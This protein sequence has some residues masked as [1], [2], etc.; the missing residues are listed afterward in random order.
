MSL[1]N[2]LLLHR[3]YDPYEQLKPSKEA[4]KVAAIEKEIREKRKEGN[5]G[6]EDGEDKWYEKVLA[7]EEPLE[8]RFKVT[9][10]PAGKMVW[11]GSSPLKRVYHITKTGQGQKGQSDRFKSRSLY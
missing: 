11:R 7:S 6:G 9:Y 1:H 2:N 8:T 5:V 4:E 3:H 10:K